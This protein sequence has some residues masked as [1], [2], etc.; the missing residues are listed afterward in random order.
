MLQFCIRHANFDT[1]K[2]KLQLL[3]V[4]LQCNYTNIYKNDYKF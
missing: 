4:Y 3:Y 2:N 1:K